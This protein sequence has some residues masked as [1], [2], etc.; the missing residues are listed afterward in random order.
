MGLFQISREL[1][2]GI[3]IHMQV[4]Q[5][6][7]EE[8]HFYRGEKEVGR[9]MAN[10]EPTAFNWLSPCQ[11]RGGVFHLPFGLCCYHRA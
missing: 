6:A 4:P 3:C 9:T 11:E 1:R 10:K 2:F 5:M 8:E 7:R